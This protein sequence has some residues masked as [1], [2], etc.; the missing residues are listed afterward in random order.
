MNS[1][2]AQRRC[3]VRFL[4]LCRF[5]SSAFSCSP[6]HFIFGPFHVLA[7]HY[8]AHCWMF[9]CCFVSFLLLRYPVCISLIKIISDSRFSIFV[10]GECVTIASIKC[11]PFRHL[12]NTC[13]TL[14]FSLV[15]RPWN[16]FW[17]CLCE[18]VEYRNWFIFIFFRLLEMCQRNSSSHINETLHLL[19]RNIVSPAAHR[20]VHIWPK[21]L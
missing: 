7:A 18:Y 19:R 5:I 12:E 6:H 13:F 20:L 3:P 15:W 2:A 9:W 1:F 16:A 10:L 14:A 21:F 11:M 4:S 17:L 8:A